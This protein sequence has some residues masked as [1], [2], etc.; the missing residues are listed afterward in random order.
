MRLIKMILFIL[1]SMLPGGAAIAQQ[2]RGSV[3]VCYG[4]L[5]PVNISGYGC[6]IVES[7]HYTASEIKKFKSSNGKVLAYISLGEVNSGAKHFAALKSE[8]LGK[9]K[10]WDSYYLDLGSAKT[11]E[12]ILKL[13]A[14][15]VAKGFDGF[16]LDNIDNFSQWGPQKDQKSK[17][18]SFLGEIGEKYPKLT[19]VQNAGLDL[20]SE[21]APHVDAILVESVATDYNFEFKKYK[22]RK[23]EDFQARA[24]RVKSIATQYKMPVILVEYADSKQLKKEVEQ[25]INPLGFS[26]FIGNINLQ[27]VPTF[28]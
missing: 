22:L 13:I 19:F 20:I 21:T 8:T 18:V 11:K 9:N 2:L 24:A 6:L 1:P 15:G 23:E 17:L 12:V 28:K 14:D 26:S 5:N 27:T 10:I 4:R 7:Q 3:L 16:F 25:R